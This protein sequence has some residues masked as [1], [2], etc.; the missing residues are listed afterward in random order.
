MGLVVLPAVERDPPSAVGE[1]LAGELHQC[2]PID[3]VVDLLAEGPQAV[4]EERA[5]GLRLLYVALT[6]AKYRCAIVWGNINDAENS[7][8]AWLLHRQPGNNAATSSGAAGQGWAGRVGGPS[9]QSR[10]T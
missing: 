5:E 2:R 10:A 9:S 6:R 8:A 3:A 7:A 1:P 4:R